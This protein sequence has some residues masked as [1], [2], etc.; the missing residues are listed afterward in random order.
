[1]KVAAEV[2]AIFENPI[3]LP[4]TIFMIRRKWNDR[5]KFPSRTVAS[6]IKL[7]DSQVFGAIPDLNKYPADL[8]VNWEYLELG[9]N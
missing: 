2:T 4:R 6:F 7:I 5:T 1:M 9:I 3:P 8:D